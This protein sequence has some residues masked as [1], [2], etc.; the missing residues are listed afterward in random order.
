MHAS[1]CSL[2]A[3]LFRAR[4]R[5]VVLRAPVIFRVVWSIAKHFFDPHVVPKFVFC[6]KENYRQV[7]EEFVELKVMPAELVEEGEGAAVADMPP[8]F[9]PTPLPPLEDS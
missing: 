9:T 2:T 5:F 4:C 7:L 3:R 1:A 8:N 6:G